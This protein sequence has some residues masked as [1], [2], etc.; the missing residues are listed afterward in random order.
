[1]IRTEHLRFQ[2]SD[3]RSGRELEVAQTTDMADGQELELDQENLGKRSAGSTVQW[4]PLAV[5]SMQPIS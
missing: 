2:N 1:M 3:Y 5:S 4:Q